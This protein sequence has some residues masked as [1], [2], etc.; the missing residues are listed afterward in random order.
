MSDVAKCHIEH[1]FYDALWKQS[2]VVP[3]GVLLKNEA[4]NQDMLDIF[5]HIHR[6][7]Y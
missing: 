4:T 1:E 3:L 7:Y 2:Y 5:K 6:S